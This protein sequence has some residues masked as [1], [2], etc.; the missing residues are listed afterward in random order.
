MHAFEL[1]HIQRQCQH[2]QQKLEELEVEYAK[3]VA[4]KDDFELAEDDDDIIF[5]F[6][7]PPK[8]DGDNCDF[9]KDKIVFRD[10]GVVIAV[11]LRSMIPQVI[12]A[13]NDEPSMVETITGDGDVFINSFSLMVKAPNIIPQRSITSSGDEFVQTLFFELREN[14]KDLDHRGYVREIDSD[15]KF[16]EDF[17]SLSEE[18]YANENLC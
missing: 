11:I 5:D 14:D 7:E 1:R 18:N 9:V 4:L 10:N 13:V 17:F 2:I 12:K 15:I 6:D 3:E 8:S 16:K